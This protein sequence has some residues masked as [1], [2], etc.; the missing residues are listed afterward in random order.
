[1]ALLCLIQVTEVG[2]RNAEIRDRLGIGRIGLDGSPKSRLSQV[3]ASRVSEALSTPQQ[4]MRTRNFRS[5][6]FYEWIDH[7]RL[8]TAGGVLL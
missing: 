4:Q 7:A 2:Q 5:Q 3:E 8:R 6:R 1:L